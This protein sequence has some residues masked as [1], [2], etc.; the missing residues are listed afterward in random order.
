MTKG[1]QIIICKNYY[2]LFKNHSFLDSLDRMLAED[3]VPSE[4]DILRA[5]IETRRVFE[6]SFQW[7]KFNTR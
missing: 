7:N 2:L 3:Y 4:L 6:T 1:I 5:R